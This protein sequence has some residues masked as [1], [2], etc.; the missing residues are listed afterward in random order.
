M[1]KKKASNPHGYWLSRWC[2]RWDLNPHVMD[3]RTSNVPVCLFQ[4]FRI[5]I[6]N[7]TIKKPVVKCDFTETRRDIFSKPPHPV[8]R[9][10]Q[11]PIP[12][13]ALLRFTRADPPLH[14]G[15]PSP[16]RRARRPANFPTK[17]PVKINNGDKRNKNTALFLSIT[18]VDI[19]DPLRGV[20]APCQRLSSL[21]TPI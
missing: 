2:G 20:L 9:K 14:S 13:R 21:S 19:P 8:K 17:N 4:H 12:P 10:I 15:Q 16:L 6:C 1:Q 5:T 18:G 11:A 7:Y 3:T